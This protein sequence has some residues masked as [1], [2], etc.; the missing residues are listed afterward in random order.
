MRLSLYR[1]TVLRMLGVSS[2]VRLGPLYREVDVQ[3]AAH[4]VLALALAR[5]PVRVSARVGPDHPASQRYHREGVGV[6]TRG[7]THVSTLT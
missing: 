7:L 3:S 6:S 4:D 1:R 5:I 2:T